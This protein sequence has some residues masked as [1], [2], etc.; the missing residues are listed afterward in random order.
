M[1]S[2]SCSTAPWINFHMKFS[3]QC[4]LLYLLVAWLSLTGGAE[5]YG[6]EQCKYLENLAVQVEKAGGKM[7][8]Y[9]GKPVNQPFLFGKKVLF[10]HF[11]QI[12]KTNLS[13]GQSTKDVCCQ[14]KSEGCSIYVWFTSFEY[15]LVLPMIFETFNSDQHYS[16]Y[17]PK[18]VCINVPSNYIED[19]YSP[20]VSPLIYVHTYIYVYIESYI[21]LYYTILLHYNIII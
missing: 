20:D 14:W 18:S 6:K 4:S 11:Q 16:E 1:K 12:N 2:L 5:G 19:I 9:F 7:H 8:D 21:H 17:L 15:L 10:L 13:N 3:S